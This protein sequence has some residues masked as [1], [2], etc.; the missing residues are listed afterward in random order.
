MTSDERGRTESSERVRGPT[1]RRPPRSRDLDQLLREQRLVIADV[2]AGA[3]P[4]TR[5]LFLA[6]RGTDR[7][8]F[9]VGLAHGAGGDEA[10]A[11]EVRVLAILDERLQGRLNASVPHVVEWVEG[12]GGKRGL[13]VTAVPGLASVGAPPP[14]S[15]T[16]PRDHFVAVVA[17][18]AEVWNATSGEHT[19]VELGRAAVDQVLS[20][21]R[22]AAHVRPAIGALL[23]ARGRLAQV[24]VPSAMTHGCLC[25]RH[26]FVQSGEVGVDDW[27]LGRSDSDPLRDL[28]R[29][30]VDAT[31]LR[32]AEVVAGRTKFAGSVKATMQG[33]LDSLTVP[34]RLWRDVLLLAPFE[35]A[36]TE[37]AH[38]DA[39]RLSVLQ[40]AVHAMPA[41]P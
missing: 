17:W 13:V 7:F 32:L 11:N 14:P 30:A 9:A 27:G 36:L 34:V 33:A 1:P 15:A 37:L 2:I 39:G 10:I 12:P 6:D 4:G 40:Q 5:R 25:A 8:R 38:G 31:G 26:V 21:Y 35:V 23:R 3:A 20:R 24:Q 16:V 28:G 18:L 29:Y 22:G 19:Q 41:R